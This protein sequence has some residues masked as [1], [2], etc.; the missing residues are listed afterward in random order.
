MSQIKT[1]SGIKLGIQKSETELF[2]IVEK[3]LGKKPM[4][5]ELLP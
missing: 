2:K 4:Q 1:L 5:R 3:K